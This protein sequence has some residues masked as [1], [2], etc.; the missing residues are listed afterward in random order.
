MTGTA[1]QPQQATD[2]ITLS[3]GGMTCASCAN[4]IERKLNKLDGVAAT[5]NYA[6]EQAT[7][8]YDRQA[9]AVDDL[10][11]TVEKAGYTASAPRGPRQSIDDGLDVTGERGVTLKARLIGSAVL[12]LPVVAI[13]MVMPLQFAG[14]EWW[15]LAL[16]TPVTFW[17]AFPFHRAALANLRHG[18]ATMDTLVSLGVTAAY[19]WSVAALVGFAGGGAHVYFEAAAGVTTLVL[20]GRY[21]EARAKKRAGA[22]LRALLDLGARDVAVI[23]SGTELRIPIGD[24]QVDDIF[25]TR[26]GEKIATDGE[27]LDGSSSVDSSLL[28]GESMPTPVG[29]GDEVVGSTI[30][31]RG[32][33]T[34]RATKVGADTQLAHIGKLVSDA[35]AGKA[36]IARLADRVSAIFVPIVVLISLLTLTGWL[37][38][39]GAPSSAVSA[40][41]SVLVIACPCALGLAT[42]TA[43]LVGTGRGA[44]L[45]IVVGGPQALESAGEIDTVVLDKTGTVTTGAMAVVDVVPSTDTTTS[46]DI[47]RYAAAVESGSDHPIARSIVAA[48]QGLATPAATAFTTYD[49]LG[50]TAQVDG[51]LVA[52]GRPAFLGQQGFSLIETAN[53]TRTTIAVGWDGEVR[54]C[55]A[56]A[57]PI[58]PSSARAIAQL[59]GQGMRPVLLSGDSAAVA[60]AVAA[61]VGI[62]AHDVYAEVMPAEKVDK[63]Q[64]LQK[65]G[66]RVAMVGDGLNDAAALATADLGIAMG[67]G[68]DAAIKASDIALVRADLTQ[69][70]DAIALSRRT[71][72]T[73]KGNLFWAFAY[74]VAAIPLAASGLLNPMYAGAAMAFSSLFVVGN[75]L[76]LRRYTPPSSDARG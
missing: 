73:I 25:V 35:Q 9:T 42:P 2:N 50:V 31:L 54:G 51:H 47:L 18:A 61:E 19:L 76:R 37:V 29:V 33:L 1:T 36:A 27:V 60:N 21:A 40:A 55:I 44:Q 12:T 23:R 6:L 39:G 4:R 65:A 5:V 38:F 69:V 57:D 30:N 28:T 72:G 11:G 74:N 45:G 66:H 32:Q 58:K 15:V 75:S 53:E 41:V 49:G 20:L 3:L 48:A 17:G 63:I 62:A 71:L 22:A 70:G 64:E 26:P 8:S 7:V 43:L 34:V 10:I 14:W 52:V 16:A 68:A 24:L 56:L 46:D 59:I 67:S 13:S